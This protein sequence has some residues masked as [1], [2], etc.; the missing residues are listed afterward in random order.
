M[1]L[2]MTRFAWL[3]PDLGTLDQE[4]KWKGRATLAAA[5]NQEGR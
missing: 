3:C 5:L 4:I 1:N 2:V